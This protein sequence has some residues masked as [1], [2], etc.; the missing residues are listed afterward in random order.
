MLIPD[1]IFT[2]VVVVAAAFAFSQLAL[3]YIFVEL[4]LIG[5]LFASFVDKLL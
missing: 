5:E 1:L 3:L 4:R 2:F